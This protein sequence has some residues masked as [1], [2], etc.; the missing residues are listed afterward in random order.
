MIGLF[1]LVP[2]AASLIALVVVAVVLDLQVRRIE[3]PFLSESHGD[4]YRRYIAEVGRFIP[5]V[6]RFPLKRANR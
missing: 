3:E 5:R 2:N 1:L 6:S 4:E